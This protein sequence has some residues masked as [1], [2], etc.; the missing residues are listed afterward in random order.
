M[1]DKMK[2][3]M[4]KVNNPFSSS[5][6]SSKFQ[7]QGRVLG[8]APSPSPSKNPPPPPTSSSR[9]APKPIPPPLDPNPRSSTSTFDPFDPL[10]SSSGRTSAATSIDC[11]ICSLSFPSEAEVSAHLDSCLSASSQDSTVVACVS[12]FISG[13][14]SKES[15][16]VVL[17]LLRNVVREPENGKFRRIR[18]GN[19]KIKEAVGDVKGGVELLEYVGFRIGEEDGELWATM[20]VPNE[21]RI[22]VVKKAVSLLERW[23]L[24]ESSSATIA[25]KEV[26]RPVEQEKI[27]RQVR[28]FFPVPGSAAAKNEVPDSFYDRASDEI[29]RELN[30]RKKKIEDSQLLIPKSYREK[31]ALA[32]R[33]KYEKTDIRI[34]FPDGVVLQGSF[35]PRETTIELYQFVSAALKAPGLEFELLH[36]APPKRVIPRLIRQG[37]RL[38]TL[39]ELNLVPKALLRFKPI[40]TE[41]MIFT[42][43]LNNLLENSE[44]LNSHEW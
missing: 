32:A 21:E 22:G 31:Q 24:D 19:P 6:S 44:P 14:P 33:K 17:K 27:D 29:K 43:L 23:S 28:V 35:L 5:S 38:P 37:E 12:S 20:E 16:E 40:E 10:I 3:L 39:E 13:K 36:P 4:K 41:S 15:L 9:P 25:V 34:Q 7:G 2:G 30:L 1:K 8:T 18:M 42:G 26:S 11:P